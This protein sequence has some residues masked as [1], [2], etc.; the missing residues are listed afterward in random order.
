MINGYDD[1]DNMIE[2]NLQYVTQTDNAYLIVDENDVEQWIPK[3]KM[4]PMEVNDN[5]LERKEFYDFEI[6][7]WLAIKNGMV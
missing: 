5:D 1:N 4:S 6:E 2:I 7:E 3:S